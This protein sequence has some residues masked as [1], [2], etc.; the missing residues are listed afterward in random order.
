MKKLLFLFLS[1]FAIGSIFQACDD[2]KTYAEMLEDEKNAVNKFISDSAIHIISQEEFEKRDSTTAVK[3]VDGASYD[4]FVA[5]SNGVYMQVVYRGVE[6][7]TDVFADND[8]ICVR[9]LEKNVATRELTSFNIFLEEYPLPEY[10]VNPAVFRYV[11]NESTYVAAG[12]FLEMDNLWASNYQSTVVPQGWLLA[13]PY[14][15]N[16]AHIR[17]IVPSKMGHNTAQQYVT[18]YY[19]DIRKLSKALS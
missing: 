13:L 17:L 9:Y 6:D 4:E 18:P 11:N 8:I 19:Y 14:L 10:Y 5:F 1:L 15:R 16:N 12:T 2:S 3:G 7:E